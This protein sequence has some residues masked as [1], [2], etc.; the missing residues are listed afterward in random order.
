[1]LVLDEGL[2]H[3][4]AAEVLDVAESTVSWRLNGG[5]KGAPRHGRG[6]EKVDRMSEH[7]DMDDLKRLLSQSPPPPPDPG[8][9]ARAL[10][11]ATAAFE[12]EGEAAADSAAAAEEKKIETNLQGTTDASVRGT[13]NRA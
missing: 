4:E 12:A 5:P 7:D 8:A 6:R 1:M 3:A 2:S 11:A 9:R 10:A 13:G